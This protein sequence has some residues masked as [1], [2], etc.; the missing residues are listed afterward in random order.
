MGMS[1]RGKEGESLFQIASNQNIP[2]RSDCGGQGRCGKCTVTV[3]PADHLSPAT[4]NESKLLNSEQ[5]STGH[6]L[7][8]QAKLKGTVRVSIPETVLDGSEAM[9]KTGVQGVFSCNPMVKR[10]IVPAPS[11]SI[12]EDQTPRDFVEL[13]SKAANDPALTFNEPTAIRTLGRS[14]L[15]REEITLVNHLKKGI[16]AVFAGRRERSLGIAL[17]IGTTTLAAYLCD[18]NAGTVVAS[19]ASA[20][21]QRR[22]GEDVISRITFANEQDSGLSVLQESVVNEVNALIRRCLEDIGAEKA[23]IDEATVVGNTAMEQIFMG[24]HPHGL[25]FSP[26]L[27]VS[28]KPQDLRAAEIGLDLNPGTNVYV[29]PVISGFVGGDTLGVILSERP[30]EKEEISLIVDIGTNGEVVL[31]NR[32]GLWATSC[33]TGPALEGAHI[34]CGMRA[35]AGAIHR[36]KIDPKHYSVHCQVLGNG[37]KERPRGICGSG[38]IDA[39]AGMLHAGL[40]VPSGRIQEGLPGVMVDEKQIG[41]KFVLVS[42]ERSATD[43]EI[44]VTLSDVRQ[45]QLAKA[46]LFLGIKLLM[47]Q[48]GLEQFDR[49]VLTGAFGARFEWRNAVTIGM[50]P[51]ISDHTE[52]KVVENAAGSGAIMALLDGTLRKE[53]LGVAE[54]VK[55]IELAKD[56]DFAA[57]FPAATMFPSIISK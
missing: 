46:A 41:R 47:R 39:V 28:Y 8:C 30:H 7:A 18:L 52:V 23:D 33:A 53:I 11:P 12:S 19:A 44:T 35:A 57:E 9:G 29:F 14:S 27:P 40:I 3:N 45:I 31:G 25:G 15:Y 13:I 50:L 4:E 34:H 42:S 43:H 55:Y 21:P 37:E 56:P 36:V 10:L 22:F 48:A 24:I 17:D 51:E 20:N 49:L 38:I 2:I 6:R 32:N 54:K 5:T 16:T 26:Y 1:C